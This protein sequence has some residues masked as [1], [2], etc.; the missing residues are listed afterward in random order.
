[1]WSPTV[2]FIQESTLFNHDNAYRNIELSII[3]YSHLPQRSASSVDHSWIDCNPECVV[4]YQVNGHLRNFRIDGCSLITSTRKL[5]VR[6]YTKH[7]ICHVPWIWENMS[8]WEFITSVKE[9]PKGWVVWPSLVSHFLFNFSIQ[10][11]HETVQCLVNFRNKI[12]LKGSSIKP[13]YTSII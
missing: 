8:I 3:G 2:F 5:F 6:S 13:T 9:V 10:L 4:Q 7:V 11:N 1:M 12:Y